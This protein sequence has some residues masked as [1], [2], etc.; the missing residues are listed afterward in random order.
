MRWGKG[1]PRRRTSTANW[2]KPLAWDRQAAAAGKRLRVF[3]FSLGD[4]FDIEVPDDWRSDFFDLMAR[5]TAIDWLIL[6]KR[7]ARPRHYTYAAEKVWLGTSL[8]SDKD[9]PLAEAIVTAPARVHW[10][11]YEPALGPLSVDKLPESIRWIVVGGESG[12]KA[13]T[14]DVGWAREIVAAGRE[15]GRAVFVKQL[16]AR[17]MLEGAPYPIGDAKGG[18]MQGWPTDLRVREFPTL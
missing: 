15:S 11:S 7:P 14:F 5:T 12:P 3:A 16:G 10:V 8:A 1:T 2:R 17:P 6:T 4:V 18:E 9:L 13:R